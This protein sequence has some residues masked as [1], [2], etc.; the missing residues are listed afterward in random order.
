MKIFILAI[1]MA[2]SLSASAQVYRCTENGKAVYSDTPCAGTASKVIVN[3]SPNSS[4]RS[5]QG[6]Q[7][8]NPYDRELRGLI[9][10]ALA[11]ND[12][13]KAESLAVTEAHWKLISEAKERKAAIDSADKKARAERQNAL[14]SHATTCTGQTFGGNILY[15]HCD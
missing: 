4:S 9:A 15:S 1:L 11:E 7:P 8:D 14:R 10:R 3:S 2:F 13:K 12:F 5:A 6:G